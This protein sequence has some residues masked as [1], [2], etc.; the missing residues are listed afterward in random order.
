MPRSRGSEIP[1][2][3]S[4]RVPL[5]LR[6]SSSE[7]DGV[8]SSMTNRPTVDRS[9]KLSSDRRSPRNPIAE[10][11]RGTRISDLETQLGQAQEELKKLKEQL[12]SSEAAKKEVQEE[13]ENTKK[14]IPAEDP[15]QTDET[16]QIH[17]TQEKKSIDIALAK[18][19]EEENA[20]D[21]NSPETDVFEVPAV[22]GPVSVEPNIEVGH[23]PEQEDYETKPTEE[24]SEALLAEMEKPVDSPESAEI[25]KLNVK[26]AEKDE[27]LESFCAEN[28]ELK[29]QV[30]EA[31]AEAS[32]A[33]AKEEE[34]ALKL[35]HMGMELEESKARMAQ[36]TEE[37]KTVEGAKLALET[38]MK[39]LRV[40]TEQWRKAADAAAAVL[41]GGAD[42]NGRVAERCSSMDKHLGGY[43]PVGYTGFGSPMADDSDDGLGGG[44]RKGSGIR[45]FGDLWKKK[46][47][48]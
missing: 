44:K 30:S 28:D 39:K 14:Q 10:K 40:Q 7:S 1:E 23:T 6:T 31:A 29:R 43:D 47:H 15:P 22:P 45:M 12:A 48:K 9:P 24:C 36:L 13:L 2:R 11:K 4:P 42:M 35:T 5:Q 25:A 8:H 34:A 38:E 17:E 20:F 18:S 16:P 37:L 32:V 41:A 33:R 27:E 21:E 19:C 26:L 46:G 3:R